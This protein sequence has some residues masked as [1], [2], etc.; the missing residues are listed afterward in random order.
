MPDPNAQKGL[1]ETDGT[2][3]R[4]YY[5][6]RNVDRALSIADLRARTHKLM[7]RFVLEY[8][9]AGAGEEATLARERAAFAEWRFLPHVFRDVSQRSARCE[10]LGQKTR[11]PLAIAPT[12]LN[13]LFMRR[14]DTA[15][16]QGAAAF[17]VPFTQSTMSN[18]RLEDV[19]KTPGLRHWWQL[20]LF[21][22]EEIWQELVDRAAAAGCEALVLTVNAQIFGQRNWD[23]RQRIGKTKPTLSSVF[24]TALHPRWLATTLNRGMPPFPNVIDFVPKNKRSF[25]KSASWIREQMPRDMSWNDVAKI[26]ARWK[27]PLFV[28]GILHPDDARAAL[29]SGIDGIILGSHGGRQADWSASPLDVLPRVRAIVGEDKLIYMAG[30]IRRGT[31]ILKALALGADA[32]MTGRATLYGLCAYGA[33]GVERALEILEGEVLNG[34]G[35]L[36]VADLEGLSRDILVAAADLPLGR[37]AVRE[38]QPAR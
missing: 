36:G 33:R 6:G 13:G 29:D 10:L 3:R 5:T 1:V 4:I 16:A 38:T 19:A 20:Y 18:D 22:G 7:P 14:G 32:V 37:S 24:N 35:Q 30:G 11:L 23:R 17:G 8:L 31:D 2:P 28:K 25:F 15:L 26:R 27:R 9:E 12:G 21:G 34:M